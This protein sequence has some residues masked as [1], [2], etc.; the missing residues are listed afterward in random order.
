MKIWCDSTEFESKAS[1]K[2]IETV[3]KSSVSS[4]LIPIALKFPSLRGIFR[5]LKFIVR[6]GAGRCDGCFRETVCAESDVTD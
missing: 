3:K 4:I 1:L 2:K 5:P 6:F